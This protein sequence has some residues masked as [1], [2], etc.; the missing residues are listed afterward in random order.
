MLRALHGL[1][2][3]SRPYGNSTCVQVYCL[4]VAPSGGCGLFLL[5][6]WSMNLFIS[7]RTSLMF[8]SYFHSKPG[9]NAKLTFTSILLV[10]GP[11]HVRGGVALDT[12][13]F[14]IFRVHTREVD[15]AYEMNYRRFLGVGLK[16][17]VDFQRVNP[18]LVNT[19]HVSSGPHSHG[20]YL[21]DSGRT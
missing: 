17:T 14:A 3:V 16:R 1:R 12:T 5:E 15:L 21:S 18:I 13:Y 2:L 8:F 19:L 6:G 11:F 20:W 4:Y 7:L 10:L 9:N